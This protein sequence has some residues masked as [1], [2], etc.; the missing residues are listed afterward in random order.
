[1]KMKVLASVA[2]FALPGCA[3]TS[4][5]PG[6]TVV[7]P[8]QGTGMAI[9]PQG[10]SR[11]LELLASAGARSDQRARPECPMRIYKG[12]RAVAAMPVF[13]ADTTREHRIVVIPP[14]CTPRP[15]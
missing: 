2:L 8:P 12:S 6:A 1:M 4:P 5:Q 7:L 9:E 11:I 10:D 3:A 14:G 13:K 15:A